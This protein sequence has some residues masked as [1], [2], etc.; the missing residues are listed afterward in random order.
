[1][2]FLLFSTLQPIVTSI[3]CNP[4]GKNAGT[5]IRVWCTTC[6]LENAAH[7]NRGDPKLW[8]RPYCL[9][10]RKACRYPRPP[11][12]MTY[13]IQRSCYT[14]IECTTCSVLRQTAAQVSIMSYNI[15]FPPHVEQLFI[16]ISNIFNYHYYYIV[17]F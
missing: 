10:S 4:C 7:S 17:Y 5:R 12:S 16:I 6:G 9:C 2:L 3:S 11:A 13:L 14:P 8:P 15:F 1:M